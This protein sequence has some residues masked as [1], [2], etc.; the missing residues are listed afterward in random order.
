[1]KIEGEEMQVDD[2]PAGDEME[3]DVSEFRKLIGTGFVG[4]S[5]F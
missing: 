5:I 4:G 2:I 3:I 1:M